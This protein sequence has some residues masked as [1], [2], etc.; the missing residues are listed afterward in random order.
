MIKEMGSFFIETPYLA[1][2]PA[3]VFL[4]AWYMRDDIVAA[5][6]A[7]SWSSYAVLETLNKHRITCSGECN[8]RVDLLMIY[9]ALILISVAA[10]VSIAIGVAVD[11]QK[12]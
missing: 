1:L 4:F 5:I 3:L 10:L 9:P 11:S 7:F 12:R 8:I 2:A 6:A